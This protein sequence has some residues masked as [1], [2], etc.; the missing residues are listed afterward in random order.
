MRR[1]EFD[2]LFITAFDG[3]QSDATNRWII[4]LFAKLDLLF[5][6]TG[7]VMAAR[8]LDRRMKGCK[9]LNDDFPLDIAATSATGH[10]R[11]QLKGSFARSKIRNV[12]AQIGVDASDQGDIWK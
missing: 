9:G 1:G 12:Q 11:E 7:E 2:F 10:L 6:K 3:E 5:V 4:Q 8:V